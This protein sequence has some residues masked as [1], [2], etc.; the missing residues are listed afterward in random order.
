MK[1]LLAALLVGLFISSTVYAK[2]AA[3]VKPLTVREA[4]EK[5]QKSVA[6]VTYRSQ[7]ICS[8]AKIGPGQFLTAFHCLQ[9]GETIT[10]Q[11]GRILKIKSVLA[12]MQPKPVDTANKAKKERDED[13]AI[14]NTVDDDESVVALELGCNDTPYLGMQVAYAGFPAPT[15]YAYGSGHITSVF[16]MDGTSNNLDYAMD[17]HA[18]PGASG[19]AVI[20]MDTGRVIGIL[21]EGVPSRVGFY[22]VGIES[23]KNLDA[24]G[25]GIGIH[26]TKVDLEDALAK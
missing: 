18:A 17:V 6:A 4:A 9:W 15:Q 11:N 21:T 7:T 14:L 10:L 3:A 25:P 19:S 24:C 8:A 5:L 1:K 16:P 13:W 12:T 26:R 2:E 22:M 20:S 23:V